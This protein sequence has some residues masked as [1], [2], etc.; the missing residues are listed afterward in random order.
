MAQRQAR[1]LHHHIY[2]HPNGLAPADI[3]NAMGGKA[4]NITTIL[5]EAAAMVAPVAD[6]VVP[7]PA[8]AAPVVP[9]P[10][11]VVEAFMKRLV[12]KVDNALPFA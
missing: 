2:A 7:P 12:A 3:L 9:E 6:P 4:K 11:L 10:A 5:A 8:V 1:R